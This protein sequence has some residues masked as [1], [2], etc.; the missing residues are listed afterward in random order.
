MSEK[1]AVLGA[2]SWGSALAL[3]LGSTG[4][5]VRLWARDAELVE[6][7]QRTH[8]NTRYLP[9]NT[10]TPT[11]LPTLNLEEAVSGAEVVV[12]AVPSGAFRE[13]T[14]QSASY[15]APA[16]PAYEIIQVFHDTKPTKSPLLIL[17]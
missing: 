4:R 9:N 13:V 8:I 15:L 16:T 17:P 3:L 11:V 2:G 10:L 14:Q 5:E 6:S 7:I 1:I 12:W